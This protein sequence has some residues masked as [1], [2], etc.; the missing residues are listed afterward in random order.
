[1]TTRLFF[2]AL[3]LCFAVN[4]VFATE[5]TACDNDEDWPPL[6]YETEP[7]KGNTQLRGFSV[8]LLSAI[9]AEHGVHLRIVRQPFARCMA[10]VKAGQ[11]DMLLHASSNPVR[12]QDYHLTHPIFSLTPALLYHRTR[13]NLSLLKTTQVL[14]R[15]RVCAVNGSNVR[16]LGLSEAAV[17]TTSYTIESIIGKVLR[18]RCDVSPV[19]AEAFRATVFK[20]E[21]DR[22]RHSELGLLY[23]NWLPR[24]NYHAML[25]RQF[26]QAD[27]WRQRIDS[28]LAQMLVDGR[29]AALAARYGL[30][31][32]P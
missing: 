20:D 7:G 13:H 18:D 28:S 6:L 17:D 4:V 21:Q 27:M 26:A 5:L 23:P 31:S 14:Q 3:L 24:V 15:Y 1:M 16:A 2:P 8:E 22:P 29:Y 32:K 11:F 9:L 30:A 19:V 10:A 25:S 12:L